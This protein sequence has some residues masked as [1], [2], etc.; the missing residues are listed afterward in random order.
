MTRKQ[1]NLCDEPWIKVRH[2]NGHVEELGLVELFD[3]LSEFD[4]LAGESATQN[5]ATFRLLEA[6]LIGALRWHELFEADADAVEIWTDV[7]EASNLGSLVTTYLETFRNRFNLFDPDLPFFQVADLRTKKGEYSDASVL[8][9]DVGPGLFST[10]TQ[11]ASA[12]LLPAVAARWLVYT[13]AYDISGIKSGALG[14]PRVKGGKGY[15]IGT[16]WVG[17][18]GSVQLMG[19]T[20]RDTLLLNLP[21]EG[22]LRVRDQVLDEDLPPWEREQD[23]AAPRSEAELLPRGVVDVLTWQQRRVRLIPNEDGTRVVG[24][25][26]CNGDKIQR[27]NNFLDPTTGYRYSPAQTK[28]AGVAVHFPKTHDPDLTVW[29]GVQSLMGSAAPDQSQQDRKANVLNQLGD[30]LGT[31]MIS[32]YPGH[33][34]VTRITGISYGTQDAVVDSEISE[35]LPIRIQLLTAGPEA[36]ELR[37]LVREVINRV[38]SFRGSM[39]WFHRRLL[40]SAGD[41]PEESPV[42][43]VQAWLAALE[44][45]F[46]NWLEAL[47][48]SLDKLA[49]QRDWTRRMERVTRRFVAEAVISAG[50]RAARG[51]IEESEKGTLRIRSSAADEEWILS[52]LRDTLRE[53][54]VA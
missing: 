2:T 50:P 52:K 25:L 44:T 9:P 12:S 33:S 14:D 27:A 6:V 51:W 49:A 40:I 39:S 47:G 15:P 22:G 24:A 54:N 3:R 19:P 35:T 46:L 36:E 38:L 31:A 1:F 37:Q 16:G 21:I 28:M 41:S 45:Q 5:Q 23:T 53:V 11:D 20:L 7:H 8:V 17:A 13:Q 48:D 42:A 10:S 18:I 29:R 43:P 30:R 26:I 34:T 4:D 32:A